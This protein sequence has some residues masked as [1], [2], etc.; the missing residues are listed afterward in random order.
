MNRIFIKIL[1]C[2]VTALFLS[3]VNAE[4]YKWVDENGRTY[5]GEKPPV[6]DASKIDIKESPGTEDNVVKPGVDRDKLL[7]IYEEERKQKKEQKL[8]AEK[9]RKEKEKYCM[10]LKNDIKDVQRGGSFYELDEKGERK[11]LSEDVVAKR[12]KEMQDEYSKYCK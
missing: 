4:V 11:Y 2:I 9:E 6:D 7:E 5:Y 12:K 8:Q 1:A 3:T 10:E